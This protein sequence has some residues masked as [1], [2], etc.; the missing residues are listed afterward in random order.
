[1]NWR[2]FWDFFCLLAL[3]FILGFVFY[4]VGR[5]TK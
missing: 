1:M 4:W 5:L 3:I 2:D